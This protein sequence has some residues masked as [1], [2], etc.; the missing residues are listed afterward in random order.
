M[1]EEHEFPSFIQRVRAGDERAA[2]ELV[3]LYEPIIRREVR[4]HLED[5]QLRRLFD[6]MDICQSVLA[7]FFIRAAVGQYE[8]NAPDQLGKLLVAMT[9]NKLASA[10][11]T[12]HRLKRDQRKDA[13]IE[14]GRV[15]PLIDPAPLPDETIVGRELLQRVRERLS[16]E[17]RQLADSRGDG[18]SWEEIAHRLGGSAQA[19]RMQLARAVDRVSAE[20][21]LDLDEA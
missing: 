7:S 21:G 17:E 2:E 19:R 6:S 10:V 1:V 18:E 14:S 13:S 4:L 5:Y 8:L 9:R 11:R 12:Q 15:P 3:R 20:L 16:E